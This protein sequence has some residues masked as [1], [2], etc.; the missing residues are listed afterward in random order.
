MG[1]NKFSDLRP[2]E[3]PGGYKPRTSWTRLAVFNSFKSYILRFL[4]DVRSSHEF[5]TKKMQLTHS[6]WSHTRATCMQAKQ[7]KMFLFKILP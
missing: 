3:R 7:K 1:I 2:E 6:V 5:S 4:N